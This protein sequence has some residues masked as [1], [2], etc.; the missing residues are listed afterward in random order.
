MRNPKRIA[1][2]FVSVA[3]M[4]LPADFTGLTMELASS[5]QAYLISQSSGVW[6]SQSYK[7]FRLQ[8]E[9]YEGYVAALG[10]YVDMLLANWQRG[11][12]TGQRLLSYSE[13]W[14]VSL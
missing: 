12:G 9:G 1:V 10:Y 11:G 8:G 4:S 7:L 5:E 13:K 3:W 14:S 2:L 6:L